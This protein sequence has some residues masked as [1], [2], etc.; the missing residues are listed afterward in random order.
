MTD[1]PAN[2]GTAS[3]T[4]PSSNWSLAD[5]P[6][7]KAEAVV[8]TMIPQVSRSPRVESPPPRPEVKPTPP[9]A[10][11]HAPP[12]RPDVNRAESSGAFSGRAQHNLPSKPE[13][14]QPRAGDHRLHPR[15]GDRG[16]HEY[17]RDA[18]YPE[19]GESRDLLQNRGLDRSVPGPYPHGHERIQAME[20]DRTNQQWINDKAPPGRSG[21]DI[22][23]VEPHARDS[24]YPA[25]D[26]RTERPAGDRQYPEQHESRRDA[27]G[28]RQQSR[29]TAMPPPR[30]MVPQHPIDPARAAL[31]H[32]QVPDR[33][34]PDNIHPDRRP[35]LVRQEGYTYPERKSRGP[36]PSRADDRR[37]S[38]YNDRPP[39]NAR[40]PIEEGGRPVP[41]RFEEPHAPTGP[42]TG[43]RPPSVG[44][45][46]LNSNERFRDSMKP[47]AAVPPV[48]PNHGRLSHDTSFGGRQ[49]ESQYGRL[50][51]DNDI[52]SGPRLTN[53]NHPPP[54]RGGRNVSAPQPQL[55]T[56][57]PSQV[58]GPTTP[59]QDRHAPSGPSIRGSPRNPPPFP[60]HATTSSAP[61]TPVAES[62]DTAGIHPDRLKALQGVGA[63]PAESQPQGGL[64][65][66]QAP[67]PVSMP[68]RGPNNN[69]LPSPIGPLAN[70]RGPPTGP[71]MPNDRNGRDKR[72]FAG[73]QN[74]LQQAGAPSVPERSGQGASIRGRGG[75]ANNVNGPSPVTSAPPTPGFARPNQ[76]ASREDLFVGRP[77]GPI[78]QPPDDDAA[79]GRDGRIPRDGL[80][81]GDRRSDRHRSRSADKDRQVGAM[82]RMREEGLPQGRDGQRDHRPRGND[83]PLDR[84][85][86]GVPGAL[87]ANIRGSSGAPEREGRDRGQARDGRRREDGP[88]RE[89]DQREGADRREERE[90]RDG[91]GS[92]RKRGRGDD[93]GQNERKFS[94]NKRPRR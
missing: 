33:G 13:P 90:R 63:V 32:G 64:G 57:L 86:R 4:A 88:Y 36:S 67:P 89:R 28:L 72:T 92:G 34:Q 18:R 50:T 93:G 8:V 25:R 47:S 7:P 10:G 2:N 83:G 79:Y 38:R 17:A 81:D 75:R 80:R 29:E 43:G 91:V 70:N 9:S 54:Q 61:P 60:Q 30:P 42:R 40:R 77:S 82:H 27:D 26:E 14:S 85:V 73:I 37:P 23:N 56:Q 65:M 59:V 6:K 55:N 52:P 78:S 71:S 76:Q 22:R 69:Q 15:A 45:G 21:L 3:N 66:R 19:R 44:S 35:D 74:V 87:E 62:P 20:R 12:T 49:V 41:P 53:G 58:L 5:T 1:A 51:S 84:D 46:S 24:R 48:D 16:P 31:I 39:I 68:P 11:D 94:D